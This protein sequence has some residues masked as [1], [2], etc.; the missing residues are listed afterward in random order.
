MYKKILSLFILIF[1]VITLNSCWIYPDYKDYEIID[2]IY[3]FEDYETMKSVIIPMINKS[4]SA[5]H[6]SGEEFDTKYDKYFGNMD[7]NTDDLEKLTDSKYNYAVRNKSSTANLE[8]NGSKTD[9]KKKKIS[10]TYY[11]ITTKNDGAV[12]FYQN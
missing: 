8:T 3:F 9:G 2:G 4:F 5:W 12:I 10:S 7:A 11:W 6:W 1:S